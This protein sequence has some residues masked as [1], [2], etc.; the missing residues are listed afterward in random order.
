MIL[1]L[2]ISTPAFDKKKGF[3]K[4]HEMIAY[5]DDLKVQIFLKKYQLN[6]LENHKKVK[7]Y[8]WCFLETI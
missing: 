5:L 7:K 6:I 1:I 4:Y 8:Q 3:T 2:N